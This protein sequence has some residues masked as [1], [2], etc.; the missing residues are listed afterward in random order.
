MALSTDLLALVGL[1]YNQTAL[2]YM[3]EKKLRPEL[4]DCFV[5]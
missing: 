3:L 4:F 2:V 1:Q 5:V